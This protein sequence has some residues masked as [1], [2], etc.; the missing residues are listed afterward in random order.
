MN[1]LSSYWEDARKTTRSQTRT[2]QVRSHHQIQQ[3]LIS[4]NHTMIGQSFRYKTLDFTDAVQHRLQATQ[5]YSY[6][7]QD[8]EYQLANRTQTI[9]NENYH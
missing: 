6:P 1:S 7:L 9:L 4:H 3:S 2:T 8:I 5:G